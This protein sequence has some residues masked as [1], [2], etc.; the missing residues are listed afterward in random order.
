MMSGQA[1]RPRRISAIVVAACA[2]AAVGESPRAGAARVA[3]SQIPAGLAPLLLQTLQEASGPSYHLVTDA[4]SPG[5]SSLPIFEAPNRS[6]G[7]T[8]QFTPRGVIIRPGGSVAP[9]ELHLAAYGSAD[10]RH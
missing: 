8:T 5:A 6:H 2:L 3:A 4:T 10:E 9:L 1:G 7:F